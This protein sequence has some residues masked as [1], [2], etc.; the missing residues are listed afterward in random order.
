MDGV[1]EM[2]MGKMLL[3]AGAIGAATAGAYAVRKRRRKSPRVLET[4]LDPETRVLYAD[5]AEHATH[6]EPTA[7]AR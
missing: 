4:T 7:K 3:V 6:V 1:D 2:A 5:T